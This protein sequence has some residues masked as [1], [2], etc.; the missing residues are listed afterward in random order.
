MSL[1]RVVKLI[2]AIALPL[3][4]G[5]LVGAFTAEA[6]PTWYTTLTPP[7]FNPPNWVFGPMWT[8]L[9]VLM[10]SSLFLV[11]N[12]KPGKARDIAMV[13]FGLQLALNFAWSF[14]FF[15]FKE[16]GWA[17]TEIMAMWLAIIAMMMA[18]YRVR[19][20]AAYLNIPYLL[21]VSFAAA[22]NAAYYRLN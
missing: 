6:I 2:V 9:Y 14:L 8:L 3:T 22:L 10:G 15:H 1:P 7:S 18:F 17:L 20:L 19:P 16:L 11:W 12:T 21:W 13:I 5:A 4:I